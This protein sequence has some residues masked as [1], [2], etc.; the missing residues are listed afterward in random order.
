MWRLLLELT[1]HYSQFASSV[2]SRLGLW[3][4]LSFLSC[5]HRNE[6]FIPHA[7]THKQ[8]ICN[9]KSSWFQFGSQMILLYLHPSEFLALPCPF[10][11]DE[12][13]FLSSPTC[14]T[15]THTCS[16]SFTVLHFSPERVLMKWNRCLFYHNPLWIHLFTLIFTLHTSYFPATICIVQ[17]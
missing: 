13:L 7:P 17:M 2:K 10:R 9:C 1:I 16:L 5:E 8:C 3:M 4:E 14:F 11:A 15:H 6:L 12:L